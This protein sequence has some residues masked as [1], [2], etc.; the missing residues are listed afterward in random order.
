MS[1]NLFGYAAGASSH[2]PSRVYAID[3]AQMYAGAPTVLQLS[4]D[5]PSSDFTF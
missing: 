1:V 2:Q 4:F 3:K 5:A